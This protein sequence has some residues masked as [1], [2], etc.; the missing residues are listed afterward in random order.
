MVNDSALNDGKKVDTKI[1]LQEQRKIYINNLP[2]GVTISE[3]KAALARTAQTTVIN[4]QFIA[5]DISTGV[6]CL[7]VFAEVGVAD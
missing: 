6:F 3:L 7:V 5:Q 1:I 4:I 2:L